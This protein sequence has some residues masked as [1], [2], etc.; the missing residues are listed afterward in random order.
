M[1]LK[2]DQIRGWIGARNSEFSIFEKKTQR[3]VDQIK[4]Y[5]NCISIH[6]EIKDKK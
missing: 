3:R 5:S 2:S 6:E 4:N 1:N